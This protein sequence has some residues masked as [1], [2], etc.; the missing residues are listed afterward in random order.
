MLVDQYDA[1]P[2]MMR[3]QG[4]LVTPPAISDGYAKYDGRR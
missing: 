3:S 2:S 4:R 1:L